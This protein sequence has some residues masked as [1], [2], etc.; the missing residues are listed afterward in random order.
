MNSSIT[1]NTNS[2]NL[3]I[4][5]EAQENSIMGSLRGSTATVPEQ[6]HSIISSE[7]NSTLFRSSGLNLRVMMAVLDWMETQQ[8]AQKSME[9]EQESKKE[10]HWKYVKQRCVKMKE[11]TSAAFAA[12]CVGAL[13]LGVGAASGFKASSLKVENHS[14][15]EAQAKAKKKYESDTNFY[16]SIGGIF[17]ALGGLPDKFYEGKKSTR[18]AE[19]Y[20]LEQMAQRAEKG[21]QGQSSKVQKSERTEESAQSFFKQHAQQSGQMND[22]INSMLRAH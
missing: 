4:P 15:P 7:P 10:E 2:S 12:S 17:Q 22:A 14:D 20:Y 11:H 16:S 9:K 18:D 13:F 19:A 8:E 21:S 5:T 6:S 3:I 1:L